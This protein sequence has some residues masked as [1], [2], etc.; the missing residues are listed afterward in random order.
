MLGTASSPGIMH[1]SVDQIFKSIAETPNCRYTLQASAAEICLEGGYDLLDANKKG[2]QIREI[3]E[4][5]FVFDAQ[6]KIVSTKKPERFFAALKKRKKSVKLR[7]PRKISN[8]A[9]HMHFFRSL[10]KA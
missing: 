9:V 5:N 10:S 2:C 3:K 4:G 1:F 8:R 6:T 7:Q